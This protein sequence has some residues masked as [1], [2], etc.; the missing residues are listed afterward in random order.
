MVGLLVE[1]TI[2][3]SSQQPYSADNSKSLWQSRTEWGPTCQASVF[4]S[5]DPL[6]LPSICYSSR[7]SIFSCAFVHDATV[8]KEL[9]VWRWTRVRHGLDPSM[10]WLG[11]EWVGWLWPSF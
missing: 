11:L 5:G 3:R 8:F 6:I 7:G 4:C 2:Y 10:D 1:Q 9:V